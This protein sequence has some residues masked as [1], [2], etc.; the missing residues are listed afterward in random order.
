MY[1]DIHGVS[2]DAI[3]DALDDIKECIRD[4]N[5]FG[6]GVYYGEIVAWKLNV[7]QR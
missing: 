6:D 2:V 7:N 1:L 3:A 4:G 5:L